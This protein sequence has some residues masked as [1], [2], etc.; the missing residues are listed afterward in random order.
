LPE[1]SVDAQVRETKQPQKPL[2]EKPKESEAPS[3]PPADFDHPAL[4]TEIPPPIDPPEEQLH[5]VPQDIQQLADK[6]GLFLPADQEVKKKP[7]SDALNWSE[8]AFQ[9][10]LDA[11]SRQI[12]LNS[13]VDS[14]QDNR[15]KLSL[16]PDLEVMLKP[17][18]E[19]QIKQAIEQQLGVSLNL[20]FN[21][22]AELDVETPQQADLRMQEQERQAVIRSIRQDSEVQ[23]LE[24]IFG[25]KLIENSVKKRLSDKS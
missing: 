13:V 11:I 15:L 10:K 6:T 4:D 18:I 12:V 7:A 22:V 17:D 3:P 8:T 5:K 24:Q 1:A 23:Q 9:L 2:T 20:E 14:Y 16:L 19:K 25:A 21:T